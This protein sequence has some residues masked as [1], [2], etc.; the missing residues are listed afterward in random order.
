[1]SVRVLFSFAC[2]ALALAAC[3]R[4]EPAPPAAQRPAPVV[5]ASVTAAPAPVARPATA[6]VMNAA[7]SPARIVVTA[8]PA[9]T[10]AAPRPEVSPVAR[11]ELVPVAAPHDPPARIR[12]SDRQ[13]AEFD[14]ADDDPERVALRRTQ[15]TP[16][17]PRAPRLK[18]PPSRP[19]E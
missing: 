2:V 12:A 1:M 18:P 6:A 4:N 5:G 19:T 7:G 11:R 13:P 3:G 15:T 10:V 16:T 9:A 14:P 17:H 8:L